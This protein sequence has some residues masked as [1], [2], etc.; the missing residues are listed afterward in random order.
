MKLCGWGMNRLAGI[1]SPPYGFHVRQG[2]R[3][4]LLDALDPRKQGLET[5]CPRLVRRGL[6]PPYLIHVLLTLG[7]GGGCCWV[8][9]RGQPQPDAWRHHVQNK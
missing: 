4:Q 8:R 2:E 3:D 5:N 1:G 9:V 7:S 6:V